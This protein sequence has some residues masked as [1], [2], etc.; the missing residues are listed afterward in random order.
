MDF[1]R[2]RKNGLCKILLLILFMAFISG[3]CGGGSGGG[4]NSAG[5]N[6]GQSA[7]I[8]GTW[9]IVSGFGITSNDYSSGRREVRHLRYAGRNEPF[10]IEMVDVSG[11]YYMPRLK[12]K[13]VTNGVALM[14][15]CTYDEYPDTDGRM[16]FTTGA[17]TYEG[18]GVYRMGA[19]DDFDG[20][21]AND[22]LMNGEFVMKLED[23]NTM[24]WIEQAEDNDNIDVGL[25]FGAYHYEI[26]LKRA[27]SSYNPDDYTNNTAP[28]TNTNTS[29]TPNTNTNTNTQSDFPPQISGSWKITSGS[30]LTSQTVSG[31]VYVSHLTY[32]PK[33]TDS[34]IGL[35]VTQNDFATYYGD[36]A[37]L[38]SLTLT[39]DN[40][41]NSG[42][43]GGGAVRISYSVAES[44][45]R[46]ADF[47]F[48]GGKAFSY[49]GSGTYR[50][51]VSNGTSYQ[52][53]TITLESE[54]SI[55][56]KYTVPSDGWYE[57]VL[58][59]E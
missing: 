58:T 25:S 49:I 14:V 30:G 40:V 37:G 47:T 39:G 46:Q 31:R 5:N 29:P 32:T 34:A 54:T 7:E 18:G 57:I 45:G 3:G 48:T 6:G 41:I 44:P 20:N 1:M 56:W 21:G 22:N 16:I 9:E 42:A 24:R 27:G 8:N 51:I 2:L 55:R 12:G 28:N 15:F 43:K 52:E 38:F 13:N 53:Q 59:R 23:G 4:G 10:E 33:V 19:G 50:L 35:S 17:F 11:Y 36:Y 26:V